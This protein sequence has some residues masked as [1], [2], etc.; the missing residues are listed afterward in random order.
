M[1]IGKRRLQPP[2]AV[3]ETS[4]QPSNFPILNIES[5]GGG[6]DEAFFPWL[7]NILYS[8][9]CGSFA[10]DSDSLFSVI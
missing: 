1:T 10:T 4:R 6:N 8:I 7:F 5:A 2:A 9:F 3:P